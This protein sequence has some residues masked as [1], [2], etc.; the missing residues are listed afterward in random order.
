MKLIILGNDEVLILKTI[1]AE[2]H[3]L[4]HTSQLS[5][6]LICKAVHTPCI[7]SLLSGTSYMWGHTYIIHMSGPSQIAYVRCIHVAACPLNSA[8]TWLHKTLLW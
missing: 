1:P 6:P 7:S 8:L 3:G 2:W 5:V 4:P